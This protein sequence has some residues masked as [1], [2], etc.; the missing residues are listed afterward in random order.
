[1]KLY[2]Y[3]NGFVDD[4]DSPTGP[5]TPQYVAHE[6]PKLAKEFVDG[7]KEGFVY[8]FVGMLGLIAFVFIIALLM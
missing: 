2:T 3:K 5:M 4:L 8:G 1:M 6:L 7:A